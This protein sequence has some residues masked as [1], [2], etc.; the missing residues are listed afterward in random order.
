MIEASA[1]S[2]SLP[3]GLVLKIVEEYLNTQLLRVAHRVTDLDCCDRQCINVGLALA[4]GQVAPGQDPAQAKQTLLEAAAEA[5][6]VPVAEISEPVEAVAPPEAVAPAAPVLIDP[7]TLVAEHG[8]NGHGEPS[9]LVAGVA[10]GEVAAVPTTDGSKRGEPSGRGGGR[11][12]PISAEIKAE[13]LRRRSAGEKMPAIAAATGISVG[14]CYEIVAEHRRFE[15]S[16]SL[17]PSV[18]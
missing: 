12:R 5:I 3:Y 15:R 16:L 17:T 6:G 9:E 10:Q 7:A 1:T 11:G 13:V 8:S 2:L 18:G 4:P 14:S